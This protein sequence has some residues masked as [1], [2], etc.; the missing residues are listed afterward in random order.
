MQSKIASFKNFKRKDCCFVTTWI[1]GKGLQR[2]FPV[3]KSSLQTSREESIFIA[4]K[5]T[6]G[7]AFERLFGRGGGI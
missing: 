4:L 7:G 2:I 1:K 5:W 6:Y 3:F